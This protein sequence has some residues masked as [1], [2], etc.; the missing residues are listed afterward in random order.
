MSKDAPIYT[1]LVPLEGVGPQ[2]VTFGGKVRGT[3]YA[4]GVEAQS[5]FTV[6]RYL[7]E[8]AGEPKEIAIAFSAD[9]GFLTRHHRE[10]RVDYETPFGAL[11]TGE[12]LWTSEPRHIENGAP[13]IGVH[14]HVP[15]DEPMDVVWVL[16]RL[17]DAGQDGPSADEGALGTEGQ[18]AATERATPTTDVHFAVEG[19]MIQMYVDGEPDTNFGY[20]VNLDQI[21]ERLATLGKT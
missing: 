12:V 8:V 10:A 15:T 2:L 21:K 6:N 1:A 11:V 4:D 7:W 5:H 20:G 17:D 19:E 9:P 3:T 13:P 18:L 14:C 16:V